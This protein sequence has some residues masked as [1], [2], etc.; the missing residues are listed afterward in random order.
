MIAAILATFLVLLGLI[1]TFSMLG[2]Q[3]LWGGAYSSS[4]AS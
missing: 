1:A 3:K 4:A 2:M